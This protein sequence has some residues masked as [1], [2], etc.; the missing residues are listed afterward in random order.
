MIL[1][2]AEKVAEWYCSIGVGIVCVQLGALKL[3]AI[4]CSEVLANQDFKSEWKDSWD[5]RNWL[6]YCGCMSTGEGCRVQLYPS[7]YTYTSVKEHVVQQSMTNT[8]DLAGATGPRV[9]LF[10]RGL[11]TKQN[12]PVNVLYTHCFHR[13]FKWYTRTHARTH[14][15]AHAHAHARTHTHTRT[16]AHTRTHT[17]TPLGASQTA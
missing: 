16:H 17:H 8:T 5:L 13:T 12:P 10:Q 15:H 6:L 4:Q 2:L 1:H 11:E 14:T 7:C 3:F 9:R